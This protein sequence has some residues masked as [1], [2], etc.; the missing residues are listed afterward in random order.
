MSQSEH[1]QALLRLDIHVSGNNLILN[2]AFLVIKLL[3]S[4]IMHRLR[5]EREENKQESRAEGAGIWYN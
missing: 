3:H 2:L 5:E 1:K 4:I